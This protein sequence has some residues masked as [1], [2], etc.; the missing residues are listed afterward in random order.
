MKNN[1]IKVA[2][3]IDDG[4]VPF[5]ISDLIDKSLK[6]D[7]YEI[8]ALLVQKKIN[9]KK[10]IISKIINY[11]SRR[12][13]KK[14]IESSTFAIIKILEKFIVKKYYNLDIIFE[15]R[16]LDSFN[17]KKIDVHPKISKSGLIY[18][19]ESSDIEKI[20]EMDIDV[21]IRGGSG[22]LKGE[23]LNV[24][25]FGVLSFHHAENDINRGGPPGFWEVFYKQKSTGFMIQRLSEELDGGE[26]VFKGSIKTTF[27]YMLNW[28]RICLKANYFLHLKL[29]QLNQSSINERIYPKKPYANSLY[30]VPSLSKQ[31]QYLFQS[32]SIVMIKIYRKIFGF[33][34]QWHIAYQF[35]DSWDNSVLRKSLKIKNPKNRF[36]A[37]PCVK[38]YNNRNIIFVEDFDYKKNKA[39][40]SAIEINP[41]K[42]YTILGPVL[43]ED[44]HLSY[45]YI[46][47]ENNELFL[48][49]ET[50][51]SNDIRLYKCTEFPMKWEFDRILIKNISAAD[52]NIFYHEN[53]WWLM[54]NIDSSDLGVKLDYHEHDSE[55]HI[56]YADSLDSNNWISHPKNPVIFDSNQARNAGKINSKDGK[57]YRVFQEQSFDMYGKKFGVAKILELNTENYKEEILFKV[58]PNFYNDILGTH[59][60]SFDNNL[61]AL[62]YLTI[63]RSS[64]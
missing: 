46:F 34:L 45:P 37:D 25:T 57:L 5:L 29:T 9:T 51:D 43:D 7:K 64:R 38:H 21:L 42:S 40:I 15:T 36:F 28:A 48:C 13:I 35:V 31:L 50:H 2:I 18:R 10:N 16:N 12:G 27:L 11:V 62:D 19:Y 55:L 8:V 14:F 63:Q 52:S 58:P 4:P 20:K 3:I 23:I 60:Y 54:T 59:H 22:I 49:P 24:C 26:V 33:K 41:D 17:C 32:L 56:F 61:I 1:K 6:Q 39:V 44:F 30:T 47:E 53:K